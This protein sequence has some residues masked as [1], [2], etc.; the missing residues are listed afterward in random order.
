[1][2]LNIRTIVVQNQVRFVVA[3]DGAADA[4]E[5]IGYGSRAAAHERMDALWAQRSQSDR[6]MEAL[7]VGRD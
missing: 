5:S 6:T 7:Y 4:E 3:V 1:M 2:Q